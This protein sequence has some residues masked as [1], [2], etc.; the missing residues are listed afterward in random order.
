MTTLR[1]IPAWSRLLS[2]IV[3]LLPAVGSPY[4]LYRANLHSHT[5]YSDGMSVPGHA[6]AYARDTARIDIL[7][8]TDHAELL[9]DSEWTDI[10]VQAE[11]A[12]RP[13]QFL[14]LRGFEWTNYYYGHV[15]VWNTAGCAYCTTQVTMPQ[16]YAWLDS[17]P[18]ACA[19][20]NHPQSV[21]YDSFAYNA[22]ADSAFV[23]LEMLDTSNAACYPVALDSGW[24]VGMAASQDNHEMDWGRGNRLTGIW[25]DSLTR[26]SVFAALARMRTFGTQDRNFSLQFCANDSW[27]GSTIPFP[28]LTRGRGLI[29]FHIIAADPDSG[30]YIRR[31]DIFTNHRVKVC[32]L[33]VGDRTSVDWQESTLVAGNSERYFFVRVIEND[34]QYVLSSAIWVRPDITGNREL[35]EAGPGFAFDAVEPNPAFARAT[36]RYTVPVETQVSLRLHDRLGRLVRTLAAGKQG[37]GRH[38]LSLSV[39][40]AQF[41]PGVYFLRL[42]AAG[43]Q[44]TRKMVV[45]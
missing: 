27:M 16:F 33:L 14:G 23:L 37:P 38:T 13:G 29:R 31:I 20:F 32:S 39:S 30:D 34:T 8:V 35:R 15:C 43:Q 25:A 40:R 21:Q 26:S 1:P 28:L 19:Q 4:N 5:G 2:A 45:E 6:F 11:L 3:C 24:H 12:T 17:Q 42:T 22:V 44:A 10:G 18:E 9:T 41:A 7:G 36:I